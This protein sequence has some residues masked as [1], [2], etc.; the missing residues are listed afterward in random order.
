MLPI[1]EYISHPRLLG[2]AL[3]KR[4]WR[5]LP[6]RLYLRLLYFMYMGRRLHLENPVTFNEKL[7]WLKLHDRQ[8]RYIPLVDKLAVKSYVEQTI[9]K[10]Y[11]IPTL[12]VWERVSDIDFSV[13]PD[14]FVLKT[15][16]GGGGCGVAICRDKE[17]FDRKA[18]CDKLQRAMDDCLYPVFR[19]WPYRFVP[20]R[21]IAESY[22]VDESNSELKD[23]KFFC[24]NGKPR[25]LKVD[26]NRFVEHH[27]NYYDLDWQ[28]LQ[29][30]EYDL[31]PLRNVILKRPER[32]DEM[33]ALAERL[34]AGI[35]FVR[36]DLY[37][38]SGKIYF[39]EMTF[40]PASGLGPFTP[41]EY[42]KKLGDMLVLPEKKS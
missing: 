20:K 24:F 8:E 42:D 34:S 9:G 29:F 40:Y 3:A 38:I 32:F 31:P 41:D 14:T 33:V 28:L 39:G 30:G 13:L 18:A 36:V 11:V 1:R 25:F 15:T 22:L 2:I 10:E 21:I 26:F 37:N 35:P 19:E 7:Q 4:C 6:E 27:A 16:H 12:A 17:R 5:V 23:Y